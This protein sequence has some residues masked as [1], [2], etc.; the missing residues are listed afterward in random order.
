MYHKVKKIVASLTMILLIP[1]TR[2]KHRLGLFM[3]NHS[4]LSMVASV[5]HV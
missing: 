5:V 4:P 1:K 3:V 2:L